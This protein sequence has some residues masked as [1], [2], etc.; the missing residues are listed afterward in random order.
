MAFRLLCVLCFV[1]LFAKAQTNQS[2]RIKAITINTDSI[3]LD[4]LPVV[5]TT[6]LV[7]ANGT[8]LKEGADYK[9]LYTHNL[10]IPLTIPRG[11][12]VNVSYKVI[13]LPLKQPLYHK[14]TTLL[15]PAFHITTNPFLYDHSGSKTSLFKNDGLKING[16]LSRGLSF[17]N[18]QDIVLNS[19]LNLQLAGRLNNDIDVLAAISDE[20]NPIQPEGNTQQLQDFDKVYIRLSKNRTKLTVGDF[21]M[22]RPDKSYFMNYYKKSRGGQF[23]TEVDAGKKG[24]LKLGGEG[25]ISRGRFVR[26]VINGLEGNQGPYRLSGNN[27]ELFIIIISGTEAV[28]LD[29]EKLTRGEQNDYIIDYNTGE[30]TF[31]AK[32]VITQY[33][34]I[35]V[36]F[37]YA[38]R[39]YARSV[40]HLN[41]AYEQKDFSVRA[42]YFTEQDNKNQPFLQNLTDSNK[43]LL[44]GIGDHLNEALVP[45]EVQTTYDPKKI[46][47]RKIDTLGTTGVY[48][49]AGAQGSDSVFYEVRFSY[50][51]EKNGNYVLSSSGANGRVFSFVPPVG[52]VKQG[53]YEPVIQLVT[54]KRLQMLTV[55]ADLNMIRNTT[56]SVEVARSEYDKNLFSNLDKSDDAGY[57][58]RLN[59]ANNAPLQHHPTNNLELK[60]EFS[61]E[62]VDRNFRYVERYRNVE[63]DRIW[64]RQLNNQLNMDT[65]YQENIA[66]FRTSLVKKNIGSVYYQLGYYDREKVFNGF[67][68]LMGTNLR[69][70][71]N[72]LAAEAEFVNTSDRSLTAKRLNEITRYRVDAGRE[73]WK[74]VVGAKYDAEESN[75][76]LSSDTLLSGSYAYQ[77]YGMYVRSKD[78]ITNLRYRLEYSQRE[79]YLPRNTEFISA[80]SGRN[81]TGTGE[82]FQKNGN[83]LGLNFTYRE[84]IV[85]DSLITAIQP[86]QTILTRLEYDYSFLKRVF[87]A[88]T[89]Y[90]IGSGQE[91]RRDFQYIEVPVGQGIYIWKDFNGDGVRQLNEFVTAS[92]VER[93][94]ANYIRV[95]LPTNS[96][97][98]TNT[99]Q[100]SQTLNMNPGAVW[101][102]KKGI[103]RFIARF[104]DQLAFKLDR[105]TTKL[106]ETKDFLNPFMLNI[107]DTALI[108]LAS[109]FRNTI[110]FNRSNPSFGADFGYQD[111]RSKTFLTNGFESRNRLERNLNLR[112]NINTI[113]SINSSFTNGN[114]AYASD[115]FS[116]NSFDYMFYEVKPK[117]LYQ[118]STDLR[119]TFVFSYFEGVNKKEFGNQKGTNRETGTELRYNVTKQ[120]VINGKYSYYNVKY[121]EDASSPLAYDML[122]GLLPGNNQVWNINFQQRF[123]NNLQITVNY[124]GRK[125]GTQDVIHVGRMEAR[126]LF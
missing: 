103:R 23:N 58:V 43:K 124:D 76:R 34:R 104:N 33:S 98:R 77:Q 53:N 125:S 32:R 52:G 107:A 57:G 87:S 74:L 54:P 61:Y 111:S 51:G 88:N 67:Q 101:Y 40:F 47:Y 56:I 42:N 72:I 108:S 119:I 91:L 19:N 16:S 62:F 35:V 59:A 71:K 63:F 70:G 48:V 31:M 7:S 50:T 84:L 75:F 44:A 1:S 39:N 79:D 106:S 65:G 26:N 122:Q 49:Y 20:N 6:L 126:Y 96:F 95:F 9:V 86:E 41:A 85:K 102:N 45:S 17:G 13:N 89:Y 113:W 8:V 69:S 60:T 114:R 116:S 55:G 30:I 36:E 80:T 73:I 14:D 27:G 120:G 117:V 21:E 81:I 4:T 105:K 94:Q 24:V 110:F 68:H 92:F 37:Q 28:Y 64:N 18:N 121:N 15:N 100:F 12:T 115:F 22:S 29:G 118:V 78:S 90:Q 10:F 93:N 112:W 38:D 83:R 97:I 2:L 123:G 3:V 66:S 82:W 5:R 46:L 99:N 25:A 109:V 11:S